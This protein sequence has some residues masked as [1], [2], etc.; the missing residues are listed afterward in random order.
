MRCMVQ[1]AQRGI[2]DMSRDG[3]SGAMASRR[4][5]WYHRNRQRRMDAEGIE[6]ADGATG[7]TQGARNAQESQWVEL[8]LNADA[9]GSWGDKGAH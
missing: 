4:R 8:R 3:D 7:W 6:H 2:L 9:A 5:V 1:Y